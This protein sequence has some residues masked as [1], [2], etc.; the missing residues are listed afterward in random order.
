MTDAGK[1]MSFISNPKAAHE[2]S[3]H[4]VQQQLRLSKGHVYCARAVATEEQQML[5]SVEKYT[6]IQFTPEQERN[7]ACQQI[8]LNNTL[9]SHNLPTLRLLHLSARMLIDPSTSSE[10][11]D[12]ISGS[13]EPGLVSA[14][15][16]AGRRQPRNKK[17]KT[18]RCDESSSKLETDDGK[19]AEIIL[20]DVP[21]NDSLLL[22]EATSAAIAAADGQ[23]DKP[24]RERNITGVPPEIAAELPQ[25]V[26]SL[27]RAQSGVP[28]HQCVVHLQSHISIPASILSAAICVADTGDGARAVSQLCAAYEDLLLNQREKYEE[29]QQSLNLRLFIAQTEVEALREKLKS[30]DGTTA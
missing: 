10:N 1:D 3:A 22:H 11:Q 15:S 14:D 27:A 20:A 16:K 28:I 7:F 8:S 19:N 2:L 9:R 23:Q 18:L 6:D 17:K 21:L 30:D 12:S 24:G 26:T 13:E 5:A 4:P 25:P 29:L